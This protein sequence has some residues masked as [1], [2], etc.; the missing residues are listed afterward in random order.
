[1]PSFESTAILMKVDGYLTNRCLLNGDMTN[2]SDILAPVIHVTLDSF[3]LIPLQ[4]SFVLVLLC[5]C[6]VD[7]ELFILIFLPP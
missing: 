4:I 1:M 6:L 3:F 7:H 5:P 2:Q